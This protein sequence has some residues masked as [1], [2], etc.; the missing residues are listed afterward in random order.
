MEERAS[1]LILAQCLA[2]MEAGDSPEVVARRYSAYEREILPLLRLT[3]A[4]RESAP[5]TP[6]DAAFFARLGEQLRS[7]PDAGP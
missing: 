4:L 6:L 7:L 1:A 5:D 3:Q 2:D